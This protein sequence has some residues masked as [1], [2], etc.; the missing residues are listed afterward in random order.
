MIKK[1]LLVMLT[2]L[3]SWP[4]LGQEDAIVIGSKNFNE[5]YLLAELIARLIEEEGV[6]VERRLGLGGD[7]PSGTAASG[8]HICFSCKCSAGTGAPSICRG[9]KLHPGSHLRFQHWHHRH[10]LSL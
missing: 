5:S 8:G 2:L 10:K 1:L 3:L 6:E 9:R 7:H 4:V